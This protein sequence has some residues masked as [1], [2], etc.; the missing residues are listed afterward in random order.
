[1]KRI[2]LKADTVAVTGGAGFIGSHLVDALAALGKRVIVFDNFSTGNRANL[3]AHAHNQDRVRV[4]EGDVRNEQSLM[5]ALAGVDY[6]FHLA[7]HC[8]RR[9]LT[10][11]QTNHEVNATGTLNMLRVAKAAGVRRF[12][13]C[14]S[15]EVYGNAATGLLD[16]NSA[17]MPTTI[18]GASKLAGESYSLAFN[19]TYGLNTIVV[20][21]FNTYGPRSHPLGPYGEVVPR[22]AILLRAGKAPVIFGDGRQTRDFTYVKD[23]AEGLISA[24]ACDVLVGD[25]VNLAKGT[26]VSIAFLAEVIRRAIGVSLQP[27]YI[28]SRPGDIRSLGADITK[29][30]K[31]RLKI[32]STVLEEG[33]RQYLSW[34]DTQNLDYAHVARQITDKNWLDRDTGVADWDPASTSLAA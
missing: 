19:Q 7:T 16:E 6:V 12:I 24:A 1:M 14:S 11:P 4:I 3:S 31:L 17:K 25:S 20:R 33:I 26:E 30:K 23:T 15:S 29:A 22:F 13:Y 21:P 8:V 32:P 18:Y 9:S 28:E 5:G 10:D 2:D 34:L 27:R